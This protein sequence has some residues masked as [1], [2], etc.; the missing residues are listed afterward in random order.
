M[1]SDVLFLNRNTHQL[2]LQPLPP[3]PLSSSNPS[4]NPI[5]LSNGL[6]PQISVCSQCS[7]NKMRVDMC[8]AYLGKTET[9]CLRPLAVFFLRCTVVIQS[10]RSQVQHMHQKMIM[11]ADHIEVLLV[12]LFTKYNIATYFEFWIARGGT[13][14]KFEDTFPNKGRRSDDPRKT[15]NCSRPKRSNGSLDALLQG[16][17]P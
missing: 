9:E 4:L 3:Q 8:W 15:R 13:A 16:W 10:I 12:I 5:N 1:R 2:F 17:T 11:E 14:R 7:Q 6:D